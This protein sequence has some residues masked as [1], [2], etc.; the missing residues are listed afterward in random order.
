[1]YLTV[2]ELILHDSNNSVGSLSTF[3]DKVGYCAEA[4]IM[5][6][7]FYCMI[8]ILTPFIQSIIISYYSALYY[9][10]MQFI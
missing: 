4:Q 6:Q 2:S 5:A 10:D 8:R 7:I 9:L 1:M 3:A